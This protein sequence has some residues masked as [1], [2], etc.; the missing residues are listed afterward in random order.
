MDVDL[1]LEEFHRIRALNPNEIIKVDFYGGEPLMR[2][3]EINR[4]IDCVS[5]DDNIKLYLPT[6]GLLLTQ[7]IVEY[8]VQSN[9]SVSLSFDGLWQDKNR[10]QQT[11]RGTFRRLMEKRELFATIPGLRIHTMIYRGC[12]NILENYQFIQEQFN[13]NPD[14]VLVRDVGVWT[15]KSSELVCGGIKQLIDWYTMNPSEEMPN[16]IKFYLRHLVKYHAIG[17]VKHNCGAGTTIKMVT[18]NQVVPCIRFDRRPELLEGI[19]R[20]STMS[21]CDTCEVRN[22]CEK[23]CLF[24]Q[25]SNKG[26]IQELCMIYKFVYHA[27]SKMTKTLMQDPTFAS[28]LQEEIKQCQPTPR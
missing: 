1:Y 16:L 11:G 3:P 17:E 26:P 9:V 19:P 24:E 28:L 7:D 4:I 21:E 27:I 22:Y 8:L 14:M 23:G 13:I 12:Y 15:T 10:L 20:Y 6:N 25:I 5:S 2:F 18:N